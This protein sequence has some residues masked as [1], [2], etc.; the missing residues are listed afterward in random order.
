MPSSSRGIRA[1]SPIQSIWMDISWN[2]IFATPSV[3]LRSSGSVGFSLIMWLLG[4]AVA[5]CGT[6]VY[7]ELGTVSSVQIFHPVSDD[8]NQWGAHWD[9]QGIP[10]NGGEKN[11]LEFFYRRPRL[12]VTCIYGI[13]AVLAVRFSPATWLVLEAR[14]LPATSI[15]MSPFV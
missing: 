11:Y 9:T 15:C 3:I 4:A 6:A 1:E 8:L 12:L 5:A 7:I 14:G 2:R 10:K 13:Y